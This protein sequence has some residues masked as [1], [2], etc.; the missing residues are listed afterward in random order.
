[1]KWVND[2]EAGPSGKVTDPK[3]LMGYD[4]SKFNA[5]LV[6]EANQRPQVKNYA[7][8][9]VNAPELNKDDELNF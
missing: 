7:P 2:P 9:A 6:T 5:A 4:L 1:V 3:K 8:G